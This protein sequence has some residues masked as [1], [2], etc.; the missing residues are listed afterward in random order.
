MPNS[1]G[2]WKTGERVIEAGRYVCLDCGERGK[3]SEVALEEDAIF[4]YCKT[5]D[6]KDNTYRLASG[7][8]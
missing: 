7:K 5:C 3:T 1:S 8:K 6:I 2:T 4:P